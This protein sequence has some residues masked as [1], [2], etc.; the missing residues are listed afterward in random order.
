[1]LNILFG[2]LNFMQLGIDFT[3]FYQFADNIYEYFFLGTASIRFLFKI[4]YFP[5][6]VFNLHNKFLKA[7]RSGLYGDVTVT[8]GQ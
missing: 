3:N 4:S 1:M 6:A 5:I 8:V 7:L 2:V